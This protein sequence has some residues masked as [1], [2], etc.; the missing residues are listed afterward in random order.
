M[1]SGDAPGAPTLRPGVRLREAGPTDAESL[2]GLLPQ[3]FE[4]Y[5]FPIDDPAHLRAE[6]ERGTRFFT[7]WDGDDLV[8][9]S[10]MEARGA[11]GAVEM[12]DFATLPDQRGRVSHGVCSACMDQRRR[13][14]RDCA[15]PT[16]SPEPPRTA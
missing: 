12:T 5:P 7:A 4:S 3:V 1:A 13:A 8:A 9:A 6:M 16:P 14:R 10:S 11:P 15:S 2:A